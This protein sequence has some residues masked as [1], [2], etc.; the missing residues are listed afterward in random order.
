MWTILEH[1]QVDRELRAAPVQIRKK[2][3]FWKNVIRHGGPEALAAIRGF[4]DEALAGR[5]EG[6]RSSRL[7]QAYRVISK[8][9]RAQ[10]LV[11]VERISKHD[12]RT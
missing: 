7:N 11:K 4:N 6:Y 3:E 1:R 10:V 5:W 12:Y 2:Y 9:E 8:V